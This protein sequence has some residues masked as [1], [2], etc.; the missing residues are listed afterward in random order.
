MKIKFK[1]WY[2]EEVNL[3]ELIDSIIRGNF[4]PSILKVLYEYPSLKEE[5]LRV[6]KYFEKFYAS[7]QF[8]EDKYYLERL[9]ALKEIVI[10]TEKVENFGEV[11]IGYRKNEVVSTY[12]MP[13]WEK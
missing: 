8:E 4:V 2:S 12:I 11:Y 5:I 7:K 13:K 6:I 10:N 9:K 3:Y 1:T